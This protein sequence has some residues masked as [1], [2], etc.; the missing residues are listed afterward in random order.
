MALSL[1][2]PFAIYGLNLFSGQFYACNDNNG[3]N[4]LTTDCTG[5]YLS[6]P[7]NWNVL[8]PRQVA[9]P[10]FNFDNFGD[11]MSIL[12]Q[13]VSQEGW[14]DVMWQAMSVTGVGLN[15]QPYASQG[16]AVF[17][18]VFNL[19][20]AVF[21]L[22]LAVSVFMRN[23]TEE[24]GVAF[25]T[26]EQRSWLELRKLLRQVSPSKR[27]SNRP[28][29]GWKNWC[30]RIAVKK[31][32]RWQ[33]FVTS[34]LV[35]HLILLVIEFYPE[36]KVW[37]DVRNYIFIVFTLVYIASI[38]IRIVGLTWR[39][40]RR[41]SWDLY[42]IL[43]VTGTVITTIMDFAHKMNDPASRQLHKFFL[44]SIALLLIPRNNQLDQLFKTAAASL[45]AI[46]NLLAT[47]FV[48]FLV[49]AIALTQ[50]FGL[51]RFGGLENG[52]LN[53]RTV[54]KAL[55]LLFRMSCGEGWNQ[56]MEDFATISPPFCVA[57]DSFFESD[58]GS[59]PWARFL[60]IAWNIIS[61]YIFM[62]MFVSLI[63]ESFSYVYQRSSGLSVVSRDEIRRFKQAWATF[64]PDGTGYISKTAFP[65]LLG[66]SWTCFC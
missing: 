13:I 41:S 25:L 10:Y 24:T 48:M 4:N 52:N 30:Y 60:F 65:K 51:T 54:P 56:I 15:P 1:L 45:T 6:S 3:I 37:E 8:A 9:N 12:F 64:D 29:E 36:N 53:F 26:A 58:C 19:L 47:W 11:S 14:I 34:V 23:Y 57:N 50:T 63:F 33:K 7:Y 27:P 49:F 55:I 39:R 38:V 59:A 62:S 42:S 18:I 35:L 21:V 44:V 20:G 28:D 43:A 16:N 46:A 17:F 5:E 22:T 61:M 40:F 31:H 32:G 66:V 2:I